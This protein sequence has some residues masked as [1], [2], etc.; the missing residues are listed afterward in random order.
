MARFV[1]PLDPATLTNSGE[2]AVAI[3][4]ARLPDWCSVYHGYLFLER[5]RSHSGRE[6]FREGEIDFVIF[7]RRRGV[8]VLEVK[9]G[10]IQYEPER[11]YWRD[12]G[13]PPGNPFEQARNNM[14]ALLHRIREQPELRGRGLPFVRGY[15]VVLPHCNWAGQLPAYVQRET[16]LCHDDM[17]T[18]ADRIMGLLDLWGR[19][20][21]IP[22]LE[23]PC[24]RGIQGALQS[25]MHLIPVM[26]A[27]VTEQEE[28]LRQATDEQ[29]RVLEYMRTMPRVAFNG[30]AGSGKTLLALTQTQNFARD[31]KRT[32]LVC[33]NRPLADWLQR[34]AEAQLPAEALRKAHISTFHSLCQTTCQRTG[35]PFQTRIN[36]ADFWLYEAADTLEEAARKL[37]AEERFDAVVVDE[38]QDFPSV[39]FPALRLLSKPQD[40]TFPLYWFYDPRQNLFLSE[41]LTALP[42]N[43]VGPIPLTRNC[44]N[45]RRISQRCGTIVNETFGDFPGLPEGE[46]VREMKEAGPRDV[47]KA[48]RHQVLEWTEKGGRLRPDQ[49]AILTPQE[50]GDEWPKEIGTTPLSDSFDRWRRGE[51]ILLSPHRRF[52]GLEADALILANI[53]EPGDKPYFTRADYYVACS[54][55]KHLLTVISRGSA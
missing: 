46:E 51:C 31:G 5:D 16:I 49:I 28:C 50:P 40:D 37:P 19:R 44:R 39:W 38:G 45:T 11:G 27:S 24:V 6:F 26:A 47:V 34:Q 54:R 14:H 33:Y 35:V 25:A 30:V 7:D 3:A 21:S 18:L 48:A 53:P 10:K 42:P 32:L 15:A 55:A 20:D 36:D 22:P 52:K 4:L 9:G 23:E 17:A 41:D 43:M 29:A 13:P 1:P 2:R 8:I 12:S